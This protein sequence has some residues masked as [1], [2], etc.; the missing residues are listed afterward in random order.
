MMMLKAVIVI[1][2]LHHVACFIITTTTNSRYQYQHVRYQFSSQA[3]LDLAGLSISS[4]E[5]VPDGSDGRY[6]HLGPSRSSIAG[7]YNYT[8][9]ASDKGQEIQGCPSYRRTRASIP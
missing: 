9:L 4:L 7:D 6:N 1:S 5:G 2:F 8:N 3:K